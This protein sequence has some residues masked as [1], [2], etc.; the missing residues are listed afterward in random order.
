MASGSIPHRLL[1]QQFGV[2]AGGQ[3][4]QPNPVWQI[5]GHFDRACANRARAAEK[6][7]ILHRFDLDLLLKSR[8]P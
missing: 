4:H 8:D 1:H 7:D 3:S 5:F 2:A 6:D